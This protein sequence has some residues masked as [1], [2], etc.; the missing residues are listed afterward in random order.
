MIKMG[1]LEQVVVC[2]RPLGQ[3]KKIHEGQW[4]LSTSPVRRDHH[5]QPIADGNVPGVWRPVCI[6]QSGTAV[7]CCADTCRW[8]YIVWTRPFLD[9]GASVVSYAW[10]RKRWPILEVAKRVER[11]LAGQIEVGRTDIGAYQQE[12]HY[13]SQVDCERVHAQENE[14]YQRWANGGWHVVDAGVRSMFVWCGWHDIAMI[15]HCQS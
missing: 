2:S 8:C 14:L 12:L 11:Q 7:H 5:M 3:H 9:K 4:S 10:P 13:S 1:P 15:S 6:V